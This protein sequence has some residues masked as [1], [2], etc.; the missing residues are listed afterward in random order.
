MSIRV[1]IN[2]MG[3]VGRAYLRY[4]ADTDDLDVVAINDVADATTIAR[5]LRRRHH[6]RQVRQG[7]GG[8]RPHAPCRRTQD[9]GQRDP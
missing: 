8:Q 2:G 1:G 3:R 9:R 6:V 4:A 5:L 7:G